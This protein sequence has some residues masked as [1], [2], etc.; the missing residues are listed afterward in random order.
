MA[1]REM[2]AGEIR[3]LSR[4]ERFFTNARIMQTHTLKYTHA[5]SRHRPCNTSSAVRLTPLWRM[6][7]A[8]AALLDGACRGENFER[9]E[10]GGHKMLA[11]YSSVPAH[12]LVSTVGV[13]GGQR[14][15]LE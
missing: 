5:P 15:R 10:E 3:A 9:E 11:C 14:D 8:P 12:S 6:L 2:A 1:A 4:G 7:Q 13:P